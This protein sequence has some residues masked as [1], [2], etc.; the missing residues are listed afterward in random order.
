MSLSSYEK[1]IKDAI[2]NLEIE[3]KVEEFTGEE[4]RSILQK[5]QDFFVIGNPRVWWLS[6]RYKPESFVFEQEEPYKKIT[7]FFAGG[8][9]VW[10]VIEDDK[11]LLY[12][13][14][15]SH[16]INIIS[17][18]SYFEYNIISQNFDRFLCETDHNEFLFIDLR[19]KCS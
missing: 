6:L 4:R 17:E 5:I 9:E 18:C 3:D 16:I 14:N 10:L 13:T 2:L 15:I 19:N 1:E 12:K 7:D 8:E 11:Q